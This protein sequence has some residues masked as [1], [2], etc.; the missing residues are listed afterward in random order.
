[1]SWPDQLGLLL[2]RSDSRAAQALRW[3]LRGLRAALQAALADVPDDPGGAELRGV[4]A[5]LD[6]L[7]EPA[8]SEVAAVS[9]AAA[10]GVGLG[11]ADLPCQTDSQAGPS[12]PVDREAV[13]HVSNVPSPST[14]PRLLPLAT[15]VAADPHLAEMLRGTPLRTRSDEEIWN[16]V[17]RLL[18]RA[19]PDLAE[20]WR[21]RSLTLAS[22][23]GARADVSRVESLPLGRD[24]VIYPGLT[25]TVEATGLRSASC[26]ALDP[27]VAASPDADLRFLAGVTSTWLWFIDHDPRL[28]HC[29]SGV[30]RFGVPPLSG[31]QRTR[32]Q[33]ELLRL[34]ERVRV[35]ESKGSAQELKERLD[36]DE[37]LHSL[38]YQPPA[39]AS[40]WWGQLRE[41]ARATLFEARDRAVQ[42]G[43]HVHLQL[44]GG[45]F[46]DVNRLAPNS[47]EV[48]YGVPGEVVVCLRVWARI[49]GEELKGRVLYRPPREEV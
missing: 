16:D 23:L 30:F 11:S 1:M 47:L 6:A 10:S 17:Q 29:L 21:R 8:G 42:A 5:E 43:C 48:D 25:G 15:A 49:D 4:L 45:N 41:Q 18:L 37:A 39:H 38:V 9:R 7:L 28:H 33:A 46:A 12:L 44:L 34:Q 2:A 26:A 36:L 35:A 14:A 3:G 20:A 24:E 13:G 32:Y 31:D 19:P 27:R 40:S 22:G